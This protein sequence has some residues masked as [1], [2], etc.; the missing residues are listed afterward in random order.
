MT[1]TLN[2]MI[3]CNSKNCKYKREDGTCRAL[4]QEQKMLIEEMRL[5]HFWDNNVDCIIKVDLE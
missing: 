2:I 3:W 4:V 5:E 1:E